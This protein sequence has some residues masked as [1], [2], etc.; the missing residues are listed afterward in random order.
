MADNQA[1]MTEASSIKTASQIIETDR[2]P[3]HY[4]RALYSNSQASPEQNSGTHTTVIQSEPLLKEHCKAMALFLKVISY[5]SDCE[6]PDRRPSCSLS[7][8]YTF[9]NNTML[10]ISLTGSV[11]KS[12]SLDVIKAQV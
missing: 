5:A 7:H 12:S 11:L 4:I 2:V 1:I 10:K 6:D 3:N 9:S 8:F